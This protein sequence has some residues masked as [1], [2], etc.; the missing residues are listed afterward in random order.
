MKDRAANS[1][2]PYLRSLTGNGGGTGAGLTQ[3]TLLSPLERA[4]ERARADASD[5][6]AARRGYTA[7][8]LEPVVARAYDL[9]GHGGRRSMSGESASEVVWRM[10]DPQSQ[11]L[12]YESIQE[13]ALALQDFL[14][15][16]RNRLAMGRVLEGTAATRP[17]PVWRLQGGTA[18]RGS[19]RWV[20][21]DVDV[22]ETL[23]VGHGPVPL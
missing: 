8:S 3:G 9:A 18:E 12:V 6:W 20:D 7:C 23:Q 21:V 2:P 11:H 10:R 22:R 17:L 15:A 13:A 4:I 14:F 19:S 16:H 1:A 5:L